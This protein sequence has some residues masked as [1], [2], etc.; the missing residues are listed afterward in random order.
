MAASPRRITLRSYQVG[1]GDCFLLGF[2]YK[3]SSR[4]VLIDFG[5]TGRPRGAK[6]THMVSVAKDI[7]QT[8]GGK[9]HAV[10]AT[11]RHKD[12]ISGFARQPDGSG[13]GE[14]IAALNPDVVIQPWTEHP[15]AKPSARQAPRG[16]SAAGRSFVGMLED[17]HTVAAAVAAEA[18][19]MPATSRLARQLAFMG[20]TN[21][22]NPAAVENLMT[23]GKERRYVHFGSSSGL[24]I[25]GVKVRVLGPPTLEQ[26]ETIASQRQRD[27]SEFWHLMALAE[28]AHGLGSGR[29][30]PR[31]Y[32][33]T[34][35]PGQRNR[36]LM[37]RV[38]KLRP[39]Q[40]REI[41][42]I[43]DK[44][45]NNTSV[46]LL[47]EAGDH[48]LLFPGDAQI[49]NWT[50][51]LSKPAVR[52]LLTEVTVYKVGHHGSMNATPKTLWNGFT[53]RS[54]DK[55]DPGRLETFIST[56]AG[57]HGSTQRDTEVPRRTLVKELSRM[58]NYHTTETVRPSVL[59]LETS[60]D[61]TVG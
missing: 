33:L 49:E 31:R 22:P 36:W 15:D 25:P 24:R 28:G 44:A 41:V 11:H 14:V 17:M 32:E 2:H 42:R 40:L 38:T 9:L 20:D 12:H 27:E 7:A 18:S 8:C 37:D 47:F 26:S 58:S 16:I 50:Y 6:A 1:F 51:A 45:L 61:L 19:S 30:F 29:L 23:M 55:N 21:L 10:V 39:R 3:R 54:P 56:L 52:E 59:F 57:K 5:S 46:I 35:P 43:L 34:S 53:R 4:F 48:R 13:S 60:F